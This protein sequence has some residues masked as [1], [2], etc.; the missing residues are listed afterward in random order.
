MWHKNSW[1]SSR[2]PYLC[3][4]R[5]P[6]ETALYR[7]V[8]SVRNDFEWSWQDR[9]ESSYGVLREVV[10][11]AIDKYFDCGIIVNGCAL[12]TCENSKCDHS[13]LVAFSCKRRGLCPSCD[14]K[15]AVLFAEH[16]HENVLL[17]YPHSH[18]VY[19]IPKRLRAYFKFDRKLY[20]LLY[21]AAWSAWDECVKD[22]F[23][24]CQTGS[25]MALHTAGDLLNFHP[26]IHAICLHGGIDSG[27]EFLEM[28]C[29]D[30]EYLQRIFARNVFSFLKEQGLLSDEDITSMQSWSHSGFNAFVG[31]PF[32]DADARLFVARYLKKCPLSNKRLELIEESG[33][34]TVRYH[35]RADDIATHRDFEPLE[36]LAELQQHIPDKWEQTTRYMG[37]Y[38]SRARG[39]KRLREPVSDSEHEA[40]PEPRVAPTS[41]WAAC[42]K[43]IFEVDPLICKKCGASMKIKSFIT[44]P[45]E[46]NRIVKSVGMVPYR[47]PP[48]IK[49]SCLP[50]AA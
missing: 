44:D 36:F 7:L 26:H 46:I 41:S 39:A 50:H 18:Q 16:L 20:H 21:R 19:T 24:D 13:E 22:A 37:V 48:K 14:A 42:M 45:R 9:F 34:V 32:C 3:R 27:G 1:K 29:V 33:E 10:L 23:P 17:A 47:A 4:R 31:E 35:K 15:R 38:S 5:R 30:N 6:E 11:E 2:N 12:V 28:P 25:V 8:H 43:K 49:L 40:L